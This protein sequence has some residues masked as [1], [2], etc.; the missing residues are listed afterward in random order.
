LYAPQWCIRL[1]EA[2]VRWQNGGVK[3]LSTTTKPTEGHTRHYDP[4]RASVIV[5][6]SACVIATASAL[7][8]PVST[9]YV[10]F[11]AV[12][13]TG[14][15]DR[16]FVRGEAPLKIARSIWVIFS[17]F[18]AALMATV[19]AGVVCVSIFYLGLYGMIACL[20]VNL[21][22]RHWAKKAADRQEDRLREEEKA[23]YLA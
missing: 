15:A 16:I 21:C 5:C 14:I 2:I 22:I 11:A 7:S 4:L 8:L 19:C 17:W 1:G 13:A 18:A 9:T 10:A 6:V 3:P 12:L 23:L 20:L